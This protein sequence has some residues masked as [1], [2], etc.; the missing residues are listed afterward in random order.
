MSAAA[1]VLDE[2]LAGTLAAGEVGRRETVEG[3]VGKKAAAQGAAAEQEVV[4][5]QEADWAQN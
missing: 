5:V 4:A 1:Q 3:V 2:L